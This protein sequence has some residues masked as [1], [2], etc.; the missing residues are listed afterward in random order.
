MI[1]ILFNMLRCVLVNVH[2]N[3]RRR[4]ILLLDEVFYKY[5]IKLTESAVYIN[6]ILPS[7]LPAYLSFTK[8]E[9][10]KSQL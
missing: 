6:S 2:G 3:L 4:F 8:R 7:F 5:Q 1:L 10:L 9:V